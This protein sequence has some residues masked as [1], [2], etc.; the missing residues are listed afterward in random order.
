MRPET[1]LEETDKMAEASDKMGILYQ[2]LVDAGCSQEDIKT[3][4]DFA[5]NGDM[6]SITPLLKNHRKN[7]VEALRAD[8]EQLECL[9][10]LIYQIGKQH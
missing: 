1:P 10:Y 7:L 3:C 4:M 6:L 2:N 8:Q 5:R 9:D